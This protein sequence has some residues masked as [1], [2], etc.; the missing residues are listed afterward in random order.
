MKRIGIMDIPS[1]RPRPAAD[2]K[3]MR[4]GSEHRYSLV[5]GCSCTPLTYRPRHPARGKFTPAASQTQA[6]VTLATAPARRAGGGLHGLKRVPVAGKSRPLPAELA[7]EALSG[8]QAQRRACA[9]RS[10]CGDRCPRGALHPGSG[11][12]VQTRSLS[13]MQFFGD[14]DG[15]PVFE[16]IT[17]HYCPNVWVRVC[18]KLMV[19]CHNMVISPVLDLSATRASGTVGAVHPFKAVSDHVRGTARFRPGHGASSVAQVSP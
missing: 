17:S 19:I 13:P 1:S 16:L 10:E 15:L 6:P 12:P 5:Y 11:R 4:G 14:V 7:C 3:C 8:S 9:A 2:A 18:R